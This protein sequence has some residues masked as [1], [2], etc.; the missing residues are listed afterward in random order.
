MFKGHCIPHF[1]WKIHRRMFS[2]VFF[3][4]MKSETTKNILHHVFICHTPM[5]NAQMAFFTQNVVWIWKF[6]TPWPI[7]PLKVATCSPSHPDTKDQWQIDANECWSCFHH[8]WRNNWL[9][10]FLYGFSTYVQCV[11][12]LWSLKPQAAKLLGK[13]HISYDTKF[14]T[15][16]TKYTH[17]K[18]TTVCTNPDDRHLVAI[19][20][21]PN[22]FV[23]LTMSAR[24][25]QNETVQMNIG[26][27]V[28]LYNNVCFV[29][30]HDVCT[31]IIIHWHT[32]HKPPS[33]QF[34]CGKSEIICKPRDL[35][36]LGIDNIDCCF[37][38]MV[39]VVLV[40]TP[41][42]QIKWSWCIWCW[43]YCCLI[44]FGSCSTNDLVVPFEPM[45]LSIARQK[46]MQFRN[47]MI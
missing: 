45:F 3:R 33:M 26:E 22:G 20:H 46:M 40:R 2:D 7:R 41:N 47:K 43:K 25:K 30:S 5:L 28:L 6:Q 17:W 15:R 36:F 21:P 16:K 23:S 24:K 31:S 29:F 1:F 18:S 19:P 13:Q 34:Q 4:S 44:C 32:I 38:S 35:F 42:R 37:F 12:R 11:Q 14:C 39:H 10:I 8:T 27:I 9:H